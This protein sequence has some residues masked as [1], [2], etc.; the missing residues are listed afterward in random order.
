MPAS[1]SLPV[2]Q[3]LLPLEQSVGS[4]HHSSV[5]SMETSLSHYNDWVP[6]QSLPFCDRMREAVLPTP[7]SQRHSSS[8]MH[9]HTHTHFPHRPRSSPLWS[10]KHD[11]IKQPCQVLLYLDEILFY[12]ASSMMRDS[13]MSS[14]D[15][16]HIPASLGEWRLERGPVS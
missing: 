7:S 12:K 2:L 1:C 8:Y 3:C 14:H 10:C 16:T 4:Q 5:I 13:Q 6:S 11:G 9:T 15:A